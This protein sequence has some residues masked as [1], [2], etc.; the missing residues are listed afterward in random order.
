MKLLFLFM[1]QGSAPP[2][3]TPDNWQPVMP[4][5]ERY[6]ND[7]HREGY[8]MLLQQL[9][10]DHIISDLTVVYES[11][12]QPGFA[13][14]ID[15]KNAKCFVVPELRFIEKYIDEKTVIWVRGGFRHWH[16]WLLKYKDKNW[17][18]LYAA[19]TGREKWPW[20]DIVLDD[21]RMHNVID[22]HERY[23]F[24]FV[25]PIDDRFYCPS[26]H[27]FESDIY[28]LC[29]GASHIH[30][31]KGQWRAVR[32]MAEYEKTFNHRLK[33]VM[34][35]ALRRGVETNKMLADIEAKGHDIHMPGHVHKRQLLDYYRTS[36]IFLHLG[37]HGQ[38][39]R[40]PLEASACGCLLGIGSPIYHSRRLFNK[41]WLSFVPVDK[42][43]PN[44]VAHLLRELLDNWHENAK[45]MREFRASIFRKRLG[46]QESLLRMGRLLQ[47]LDA[48]SPGYASKEIIWHELYAP[49]GNG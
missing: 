49:F 3:S 44:L 20:W 8:F 13:K 30:D 35:G 38:N 46:F 6:H 39:D 24:P 5:G 7:F 41:A 32:V 36:K 4:C 40:G 48:Y 33:A 27:T 43:N 25:K 2:G 37:N 23:W 26:D 17:L 47:F 1:S 34:P 18:M 14:W 9:V 10:E 29:I 21:I 42:E 16:N 11:N 22:T 45:Y 31:K 19:N 12:V 28:D 15:H